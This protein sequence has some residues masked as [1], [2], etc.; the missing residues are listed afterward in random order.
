MR[1]QLIR[2]FLAAVAVIVVA[3]WLATAC[4][5]ATTGDGPSFLLIMS[6]RSG[7]VDGSTLTLDGVPSVIEMSAGPYR[8]TDHITVEA[9][10]DQWSQGI[11]SFADDPPN[12][13]LSVLS[14]DEPTNTVVELTDVDASDGSVTFRFRTLD[15]DPLPDRFGAASLFIDNL[16]QQQKECV[17]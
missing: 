7:S 14:G 6:A 11:D 17:H 8:L 5:P 1:I 3:G 15:G 2:N 16:C 9:F 10:V 13:D 4:T 12:A